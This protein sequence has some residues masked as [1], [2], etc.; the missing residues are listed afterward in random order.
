MTP[1]FDFCLLVQQNHK[2]PF[3]F[4]LL[5]FPDSPGL[6]PGGFRIRYIFKDGRNPDPLR[7]SPAARVNARSHHHH[8][9]FPPIHP[10]RRANAHA[11]PFFSRLPLAPSSSPGLP[12]IHD[13]GPR[14]LHPAYASCFPAEMCVTGD[15]PA[16][17]TVSEYSPK[18]ERSVRIMCG[19]LA[20]SP[21]LERSGFSKYI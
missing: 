16:D 4:L 20:A 15:F 21:A 11:S 19:A 12:A 10:V 3:H 2:H 1:Y 18:R 14:G 17:R 5:P 6:F 8:F 7:K 9:P 13:G